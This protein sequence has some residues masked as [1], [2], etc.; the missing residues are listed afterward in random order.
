MLPALVSALAAAIIVAVVVHRQPPGRPAGS[1]ARD[2]GPVPPDVY[3]ALAAIPSHTFDTVGVDGAV[4]PSFVG[5]PRPSSAPPAVLYVG[6]E[7]CPYCAAM[8]WP[9]VVAL[10]RFGSFMGLAL[11]TSSATDVFPRTPTFTFRE[12]HY[13]SP[14]LTLQAIELQGNVQDAS[15]QYPRLQQLTASQ[16][17]IFRRD[18]PRGEIP[19]L[20][21]GGAYL[22]VG[23]PFSP[24]LLQ[25]A[26]WRTIATTLSTGREEAAR[27]ILAEANVITAAVCLVDG[28]VP[29]DVC[30]SPGVRAAA[31]TLPAAGL[32]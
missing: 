1:S 11:S 26:D 12:A 19:F 20:L 15:G 2:S 14:Y 16:D 23:S 27:A 22:W 18:D 30:R 24:A 7:Y 28:N 3:R 8:R 21:V 10:A 17:A 13:Q 29:A 4:R 5:T 25:G 6:A 32:R 31:E 9:L